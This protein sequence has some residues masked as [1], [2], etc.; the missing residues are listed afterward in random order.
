[1]RWCRNNLKNR[2]LVFISIAMVAVSIFCLIKGIR[3]PDYGGDEVYFATPLLYTNVWGLNAFQFAYSGPLKTIVTAP[4][5]NLFGFNIYSVRLFTIGVYL[6]SLLVWSLYL[7]K[8][9]YWIALSATLI[10]AS[11]NHDLLFLAKVDINQAT[12][13]NA[14]T[15]CFFV[16]F[17]GILESGTRWWRSLLF[18]CL[19]VIE[20]NNHIRNVWIINAFMI[21]ALIDSYVMHGRSAA[22]VRRLRTLI[23][24]K[25]PVF[26]GWLI[27]ATYF[28][29]ILRH[30]A[31]NCSVH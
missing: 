19:A 15:I 18:I 8:R 6:L 12:F 2:C 13:H 14:I 21:T 27:S 24:D 26:V 16:L 1:M 23:I 29:Y 10:A 30:F 7:V 5:F 9:K 22:P 31:G 4:Y 17:L 11:V 3:V 25:W 28:S 20:M